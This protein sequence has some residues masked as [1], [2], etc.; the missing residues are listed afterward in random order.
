MSN[1]SPLITLAG[2][3]LLDLLPQLYGEIWIPEMVRDEYLA[4]REPS[5]MA[6]S[7]LPGLA[8]HLVMMDPTLHI[9]SGFGEGEAAAIS[10]AQAC[11]ARLVVVDDKRAR[12][13]VRERGLPVVGT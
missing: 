10:M 6:I 1:T 9:L 5:G 12:R 7:N 13:V 4:H 8:I 3:G 2:V 11:H